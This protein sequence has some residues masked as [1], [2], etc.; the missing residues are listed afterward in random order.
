MRPGRICIGVFILAVAAECAAFDDM[1]FGGGPWLVDKHGDTVV[2]RCMGMAATPRP[3]AKADV[4]ILSRIAAMG[5]ACVR[6]D[7]DDRWFEA[8]H[9]PNGFEYLDTMISTA[10]KLG[11][12]TILSMDHRPGMETGTADAV[13]WDA[14]ENQEHL[15]DLW[16][17][18]AERYRS[19][20]GIAGYHLMRNPDPPSGAEY[21]F[22][23]QYLVDSIREMDT[24]HLIIIPEPQ[25]KNGLFEFGSDIPPIYGEHLA[26]GFSEY[27]PE[28]FTRQGIGNRPGGR[29]WP[30]EILEGVQQVGQPTRRPAKGGHGPLRL[31]V[32]AIAPDGADLVAPRIYVDGRGRARFER[33]VL[34]EVSVFDRKTEDHA[35]FSDTFSDFNKM[36]WPAASV[37]ESGRGR[38]MWER[39]TAS[40]EGSIVLE[41]ISGLTAAQPFSAFDVDRLPGAAANRRYRLTAQ[42]SADE[43]NEAGIDIVFLK[44]TKSFSDSAAIEARFQRR[45]QWAAKINAPLFLTEFGAP[46]IAPNDD[47]I[48]WMESVKSAC[49]KHGISWIHSVFREFPDPDARVDHNRYGVYFGPPELS[50]DRCDIWP[51][52]HQFLAG[53]FQKSAGKIRNP[54]SV[55]TIRDN[56]VPPPKKGAWVG[57]CAPESL[58]G[59]VLSTTFSSIMR[60]TR[61]LS[62]LPAWIHVVHPWK[63]ADDK[64]VDFPEDEFREVAAAGSIPM[65]SWELRWPAGEVP[66]ATILAG[67]A[68]TYIRSWADGARRFRGPFVLRL[69][70]G[71]ESAVYRHIHDVFIER[72]ATHVSW[73]WSPVIAGGDSDS[74]PA[75]SERDWPGDDYVDWVG[76]S[77]YDRPVVEGAGD[78]VKLFPMDEVKEF[79]RLTRAYPKP[80]CLAE[81]GCES[82]RDQ[83]RW[84]IDALRGIQLPDLAPVSAIV[85]MEAMPLAEKNPIDFRLRSDAAYFVSKELASPYFVGGD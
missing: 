65:V 75:G 44:T 74:P 62:K 76:L 23:M 33:M 18:I 3:G 25:T 17:D 52:L 73:V 58:T 80:V 22:F 7:M 67:Q 54:E 29:R 47:E 53:S 77:I 61:L 30:G 81:V 66:A 2:L 24:Q 11:I 15:V 72:G 70:C 50:I 78:T 71:I 46:R 56:P 64:W 28:P 59:P 48:E 20:P 21:G 63:T 49:E 85:I 37:E 34:M 69:S 9:D 12:R 19:R 36:W 26:Y 4:R 5:A 13:V 42:V 51:E 43:T 8:G 6:L 68:D 55:K 38:V 40:G 79:L 57:A 35:V 1:T 84:W 31:K 14:R 27:H 60:M 41:G 10:A 83:A 32:E 16:V 82:V 45:A 39:G